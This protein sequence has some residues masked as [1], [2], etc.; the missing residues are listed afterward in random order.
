MYYIFT[1]L[2]FKVWKSALLSVNKKMNFSS[3]NELQLCWFYCGALLV[4]SKRMIYSDFWTILNEAARLNN[5]STPIEPKAK[6]LLKERVYDIAHFIH[7]LVSIQLFWWPLTQKCLIRKKGQNGAH[8]AAN[9]VTFVVGFSY[10]IELVSR[11][12]PRGALSLNGVC[13]Y[14]VTSL[15]SLLRFP[16]L[17]A[18]ITLA[19]CV[20]GK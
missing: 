10:I 2:A 3:L 15:F 4:H 20:N 18:G 1:S 11:F 14:E 17:S 13:I 16:P 12:G 5:K 7:T 8:R 19:L 9:I 6:L